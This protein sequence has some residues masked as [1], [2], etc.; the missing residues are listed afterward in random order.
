MTRH[1]PGPAPDPITRA[2]V[3]DPAEAIYAEVEWNDA[4]EVLGIWI[5]GT[6]IEGKTLPED[7]RRAIVNAALKRGEWVEIER[8]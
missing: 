4:P 8:E 2:Y 6:W 5:W 7:M 3:G 1:W